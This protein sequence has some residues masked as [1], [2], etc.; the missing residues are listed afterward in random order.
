[1]SFGKIFESTYTG[2][3]V[4]AGPVVF[5]V[6]GY[7]IANTKP[8][9]VVEL[10][11]TILGAMLGTSA[12]SVQ[13]A[14]AYLMAEDP[15]SRSSECDGRR[16]MKQGPFLYSVPTWQKYRN[17]RN[18]E[19]RRAYNA[20]AAKKHR[21]KVKASNH[22]SITVND[23]Q[24]KYAKA[25][26]EAEAEVHTHPLRGPSSPEEAWTYAQSLNSQAKSSGS[27][28]PLWTRQ[29]VDVWYDFRQNA[30]W[31]KEQAGNAAV[32]IKDWRGDLRVSASWAISRATAPHGSRNGSTPPP[33]DQSDYFTRFQKKEHR[34]QNAAQQDKAAP[35]P[36]ETI[37]TR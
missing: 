4:G 20:K 6:W 7:V 34:S 14:I 9:G 21:E 15:R 33:P 27:T 19:E 12:E 18:D 10:N 17:A 26:A 36:P 2:S 31:T 5:A 37:Q 28:A 35:I 25:E 8:P 16:L 29:A 24:P 13:E 11:P 3:M 22:A 23:C 1:M 32:P 30:E